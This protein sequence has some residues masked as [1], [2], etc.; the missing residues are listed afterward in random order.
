MNGSKSDLTRVGIMQVIIEDT[1]VL[2]PARVD[3]RVDGQRIWRNTGNGRIPQSIT[4]RGVRV[5]LTVGLEPTTCGLRIPSQWV[6]GV[7]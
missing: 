7:R 6:S 2:S 4:E 1:L 3:G 5:E